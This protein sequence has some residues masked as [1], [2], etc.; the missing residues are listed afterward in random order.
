MFKKHFIKQIPQEV[1][2]NIHRLTSDL[3]EKINKEIDKIRLECFKYISLELNSIESVLASQKNN[4]FKIQSYIDYLNP[5]S[6]T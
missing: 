6:N 5:H 3:T 4:S 1:E 2:K